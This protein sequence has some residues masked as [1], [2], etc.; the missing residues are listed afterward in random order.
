MLQIEA[1]EAV[2]RWVRFNVVENQHFLATLVAR[3]RLAQLP[4]A[5]LI[6]RVSSD[7]LIRSDGRCRDFLDSAKDYQMALANLVPNVVIS[8]RVLPRKSYSG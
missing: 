3:L 1:Y 6:D 5:Y 7:E 8:E 4:A 2:M